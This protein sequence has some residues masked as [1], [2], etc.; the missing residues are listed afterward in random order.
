VK[1]HGATI[2]RQLNI[3]NV[4]SLPAFGNAQRKEQVTVIDAKRWLIPAALASVLAA[5][6][7]GAFAQSREAASGEGSGS[8]APPA[9]SSVA[10]LDR[11]AALW[12]QIMPA[13]DPS[14]H[15]DPLAKVTPVTRATHAQP[16]VQAPRQA[17][18]RGAQLAPAVE[19]N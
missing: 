8:S 14:R 18:P 11:G 7:G 4:P 17:D 12:Q 13:Y 6:A 5:L 16:T 3:R 1:R 9:L 10:D 15:G 19:R 2:A